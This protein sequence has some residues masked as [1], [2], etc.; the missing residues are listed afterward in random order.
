MLIYG[1]RVAHKV[2]EHWSLMNIDNTKVIFLPCIQDKG[3]ILSQVT[4]QKSIFATS[5]RS[6]T[7][8][9]DWNSCQVDFS[10][11]VPYNVSQVFLIFS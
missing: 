4:G 11:G 8:E 5:S 9:K 2:Y 6:L 3:I 7:E 10:L 1:V